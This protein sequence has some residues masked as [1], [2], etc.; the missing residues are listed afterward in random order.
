[1]EKTKIKRNKTIDLFRLVCAVLVVFIHFGRSIGISRGGATGVITNC[2]YALAVLA[3]PLFFMISGYFL[4][5]KN[6]TKIRQNAKKSV[7]K[8]LKIF[9]IWQVAYFVFTGV[10]NGDF[11]EQ[12]SSL[13]IY[14]FWNLLFF[15]QPLLDGL[16][17]WFVLALLYSAGLFYLMSSIKRF[18]ILF[19][20]GAFGY[21]LGLIFVQYSSFFHLV[22]IDADLFQL[23]WFM[24]GLLFVSVGFYIA[25]Y[26]DKL[27][28]IPI[29]KFAI[30]AAV[31][32]LAYI[33]EILVLRSLNVPTVSSV[34]LPI[35]A[36]M[37]LLFAIRQPRVDFW[38]LSSVGLKY[39]LYIY[40]IHVPLKRLL[41]KVMGEPWVLDHSS[42]L[43]IGI[44]VISA[45]ALSIG[46][47]SI[48][49]QTKKLKFLK[50]V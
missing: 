16:V 17:L 41:Y 10:L 47:G 45:T 19:M 42:A 32:F 25:K 23:S 31:I 34:F 26:Q 39:S 4:Y 46:I 1:M 36:G 33:F 49:T 50:I 38:K 37:I 18:D 48:I 28:N 27:L 35:L 13:S 14:N 20:V 8:L 11:V 3:V 6:P 24:Q 2:I 30:S 15:N 7:I 43:W 5:N 22:P 40:L 44:Y 12:V 29:K 21:A 9:V